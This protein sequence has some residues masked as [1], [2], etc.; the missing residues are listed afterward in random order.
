M[1][2]FNVWLKTFRQSI[3]NYSYYVNF[4]SVYS[5]ANQY[6]IELNMLNSIVG[7][8]N[9]ENELKTLL[10]KYPQCLNAIPILLAKREEEIFCMDKKGS[11]TYNFAKRNHTLDQYLYFMRETGLLDLIANHVVSNLYDYV[12]GVNT[13]L[14]SNA[15]KNRGGHLMEDLCE[16][17]IKEMGFPYEKEVTISTVEEKT[18][19]SLVILSN[20]GELTKRFDFVVYGEKYTYLFECNFYTSGGSKLNET[21][22]SYKNIALDVRH[23][24]NVKFVWLTDGQGWRSARHNLKDT[25]DVLETLYNITDLEGS[26]LK[27][28]E[29]F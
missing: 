6:K 10:Q 27:T 29:H 9:I 17:F 13:S 12:L 15:R 2:D 20:D 8:K 23:V 26:I 28:L 11:A 16:D 3:A 19:T 21:A 24:D 22:R 4:S 18:N 14:D 7:S 1:R 5:R 25:F